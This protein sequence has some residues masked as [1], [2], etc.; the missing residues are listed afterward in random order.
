[1]KYL[2]NLYLEAEVVYPPLFQ[3]VYLQCTWN[4]DSYQKEQGKKHMKFYSQDWFPGC[5][6]YAVIQGPVLRQFP[7]LV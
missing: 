7:H 3:Y 2:P 1:M 6:T 5:V 4:L